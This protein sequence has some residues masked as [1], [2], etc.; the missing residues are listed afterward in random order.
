M[1]MPPEIIQVKRL[2]RKAHDDDDDDDGQGVVNYLPCILLTAS[3]T[4]GI[5]DKDRKRYRSDAYVYQRTTQEALEAEKRAPPRPSRDVIPIIHSSKLAGNGNVSLEE[6]AS[7]KTLESVTK[8]QENTQNGPASRVETP[9]TTPSSSAPEPRRFHFSR[10]I[11]KPSSLLTTGLK[12]GKRSRLNTPTTVFVERGHKRTRTEDVQMRDADDTPEMAGADEPPR[13][14]KLP[15]SDR[16]GPRAQKSAEPLKRELPASMKQHW[17]GDDMDE[18][19]RNMN[20]FA[21][22]LI[23]ANLA[24]TEERDKKELAAAAARKEASST[25]STP[26]KFKPKPPAKRFAERHPEIAAAAQQET[27]SSVERDDLE[28]ASE[29]EYVVETYVRVPASALGK[30]I[31]PEKVGLLVFDNEPDADIFYG[32]EGDSD[33]EWPEGDED[34]NAENYYTADY[35]DDEVDS[36]D[37]YNRGAYQ[38]RTGNASD[39][40]EFDERDDDWAVDHDENDGSAPSFSARLGAMPPSAFR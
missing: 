29:D 25:A 4:K 15:G 36:D 40:E 6:T 20:S 10:P 33:D 34:E 14:L 26:Q 12:T 13:K 24:E 3:L 17:A 23:G 19:T 31:A 18:I 21:L 37:E 16:K 2:K 7:T 38:Y 28:P 32:E 5:D 27:L 11:I 9:T 35:P 30:D 8:P 39:L 1:S 22:Q